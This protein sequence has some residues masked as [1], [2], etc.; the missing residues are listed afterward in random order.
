MWLKVERMVGRRA[1][2]HPLEHR[3]DGEVLANKEIALAGDPDSLLEPNLFLTGHFD[4]RSGIDPKTFK[5]R[6]NQI[7]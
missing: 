7:L 6:K 1:K 3:R 2:A 5:V 4:L